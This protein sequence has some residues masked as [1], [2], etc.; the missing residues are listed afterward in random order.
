MRVEFMAPHELKRGNNFRAD[1]EKVIPKVT[2][3]G[4]NLLLWMTHVPM[5]FRIFALKLE[6]LATK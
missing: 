4:I 3:G 5:F 1:I 6:F 2:E